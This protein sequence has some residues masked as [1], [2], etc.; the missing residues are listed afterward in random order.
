MATSPNVR[1]LVGEA[2]DAFAKTA[3]VGPILDRCIRIAELRLDFYSLWWLRW[4]SIGLGNKAELEE[5]DFAMAVRIPTEFYAA[6]RKIV[7]SDMVARRSF[8]VTDPTTHRTAMKTAQYSAGELDAHIEEVERVLATS[9]PPVGLAAED[10]YDVNQRHLAIQGNVGPLLGDLKKVRV[11]IRQRLH[12]FLVETEAAIA[13]GQTAANAFERVRRYVDGELSVIGP[14]VLDEFR[15]AYERA[16]T[17]TPAALS[18]ALLSCRRVIQAVADLLYPATGIT[19]TGRDGKAREMTQPAYRNRLWQYISEH[20]QSETKRAL[21]LNSA[22]ELGRR[23]DDIDGL[24]NKG[25]HADVTSADAD[26]CI[27]QTYVLVGDLLRLRTPP[28]P[29]TAT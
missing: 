2:L 12:R 29:P 28:A 15:A 7:G 4:E 3:E 25:V 23:L 9:A 22:D 10:L 19:V 16:D 17:G 5:L 21:L 20:V 1:D 13:F 8:E 27:L 18:Q 14:N 24:A 26:Q 11:R 6:H